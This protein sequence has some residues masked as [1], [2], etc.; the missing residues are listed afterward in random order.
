[1]AEGANKILHDAVHAHRL[2]EP[3]SRGSA[4]AAL[5]ADSKMLVQNSNQHSGK[6][7]DWMML[8]FYP[9]SRSIQRQHSHL[10][11]VDFLSRQWGTPYC[12]SANPYPD[13]VFSAGFH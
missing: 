1:M 12:G 9:F 13:R 3:V 7:R 2:M 11:Y 10:I 5:P 6:N 8:R 4:G